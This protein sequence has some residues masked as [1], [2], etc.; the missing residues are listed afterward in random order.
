MKRIIL[1]GSL[2]LWAC[3]LLLAPAAGAAAG[4]AP[5]DISG[6]IPE[7]IAA[8]ISGDY[9]VYSVAWGEAINSSTPRGLLLY[10]GVTGETI[11]IA[12]STGHMTLTG[13]NIDGDSI[14]WFDEPQ[15]LLDENETRGLFNSIYLYSIREGTTTKIYSS[16][17]VEW[18]KVSG[19]YILWSESPEN[20]CVDSLTVYDIS[21][22]SAQ[23]FPNIRVDDPAAVLLDGNHIAYTD[24]VTNDLTLY[25]IASGETT[26]VEEIVRTN[27][28][29][30]TIE[31]AAMGG[32][33][34][35]YITRT[36][37]GEGKTREET[38]TL[39]LY[40]ISEKTTELL[41][42]TSGLVEETS[43][44]PDLAATFDSPFT[45]GATIGWVLVTGISRADFVTT[46]P[47]RED[48]AILSVDGDIAFPAIDGDRAV[49]VESKLFKNA[50]VV[51]A[52]R[53]SQT[54][55][56]PTDVPEPT[57]APGFG[58]IAATTGILA[59]FTH[60]RTKK[61]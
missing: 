24:A 38:H 33:Y 22:G 1:K 48:P 13:G 47:G 3:L 49:W 11:V 31:S 15:I 12:N 4:W 19:N 29:F 50:H 16:E 25:D 56:T 40:T 41:S 52:T 17:T 20:T 39:S 42:P 34:L 10:S 9:V 60:A 51:M 61:H 55:A 43:T 44:K 32:D 7:P 27:T 53:G 37:E 6:T 35:L 59:A 54:T 2:I 5:Q 46:N 26:V 21:E 45:D 28:T 30:S 58:L 14:V 36:V 23:D 18:P 8:D 57:P